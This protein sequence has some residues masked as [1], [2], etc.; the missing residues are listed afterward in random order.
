MVTAGLAASAC[1]SIV[2][3]KEAEVDQ[4]VAGERSYARCYACH[5]LSAETV[6]ADG[7]HL[8]GIVGRRVAAVPGYRYSKAL[9][10]YAVTN[11]VWTRERLDAFLA[12]PARAAPGNAMGFFGMDDPDERAAL[13]AW[14]AVQR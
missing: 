9:E 11:P 6:G 4:L 13:I 7:P 5:G 2:A 10:G 14:L 8:G 3:A 12:D 1:V